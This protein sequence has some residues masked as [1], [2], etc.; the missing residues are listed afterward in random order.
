MSV[1]KQR[2]EALRWLVTAEDDY[3]AAIILKDNKKYSLACFH[4][5]QAAEKAVKA[6]YYFINEEPWGHSV[7][8]L[9]RD[10]AKKKKEYNKVL[11]PLCEGAMKLDQYYIPTRYPNGLPDII[12]S[13]AYS[14]SDAESALKI[15]ASIIKTLK[16]IIKGK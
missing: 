13:E 3:S 11:N 14:L 4:S 15:A 16:N 1:E 8:K 7:Y 10:I 5:Q 2:L 9:I 6:F 12:P